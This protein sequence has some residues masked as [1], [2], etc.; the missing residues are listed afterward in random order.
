MV[1]INK[2]NITQEVLEG[3]EESHGICTLILKAILHPPVQ[4]AG[5]EGVGHDLTDPG[6]D[7]NICV[8]WRHT[9]RTK[10]GWKE[11]AYKVKLSRRIAYTG[12]GLLDEAVHVST[13]SRSLTRLCKPN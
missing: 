6:H 11:E 5:R 4:Q 13:K 12:R 2:G 9:T 10:A 3:Q 8:C 7:Q 1:L